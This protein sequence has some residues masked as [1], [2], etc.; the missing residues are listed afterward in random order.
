MPG[1]NDNFWVSPWWQAA[2]LPD[3]WQICGER[4]LSL[5]VWHTFALESVGNHYLCGGPCDRDDASGLLVICRLN[6]ANGRRL[7]ADS[8]FRKDQ[9]VKACSI[10]AMHDWV[11]VDAECV[12]YVARCTRTVSRWHGKESGRPAAVPYQWHLLSLISG[13]DPAKFEAAWDCPYAVAR[14]LFDAH[15]EA[16]GDTSLLSVTAQ[17]MEDNWPAILAELEA[18]GEKVTA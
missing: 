5:S 1:D 17:K 16:N 12:D 14:C 3:S 10:V 4:V 2:L 13:N 9:L 18:K 6:H 15:A 7:L 8:Y 11:Q